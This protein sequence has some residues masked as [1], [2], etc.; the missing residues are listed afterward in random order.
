MPG[1]T[2]SV[3]TLPLLGRP[4]RR[5]EFLALLWAGLAVLQAGLAVTPVIAGRTP[6]PFDVVLAVGFLALGT[7]YLRRPGA[8]RN[9]TDPAPRWWYGLVAAGAV[10]LSLVGVT[11]RYV[12]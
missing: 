6:A 1:E 11:L 4:L 5:A 10:V 9:G 12:G 3:P 7:V 8:V 2:D